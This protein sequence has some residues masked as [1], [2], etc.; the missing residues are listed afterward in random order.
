MIEGLNGHLISDSLQVS[1]NFNYFLFLDLVNGTDFLSRGDA[2]HNERV[3]CKAYEHD[4]DYESSFVSC[5]RVNI[6]IAYCGDGRHNEVQT[7]KIDVK[8]SCVKVPVVEIQCSP[9]IGLKSDSSKNTRI[10]MD[11]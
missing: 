4:E 6:P 8:D 10:D 2:C 7:R 9:S 11:N 3:S 1:L 5:L